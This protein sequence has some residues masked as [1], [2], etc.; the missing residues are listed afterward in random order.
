MDDR[1]E[2]AIVYDP[3]LGSVDHAAKQ[4]LVLLCICRG[5]AGRFQYYRSIFCSTQWIRW[6]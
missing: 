4:L 6:H 2:A 5:A 1:E 3:P